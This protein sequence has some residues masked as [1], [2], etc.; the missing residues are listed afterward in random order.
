MIIASVRIIPL[1]GKRVEVLDILRHVQGLLHASAG[2]L[3]CAIYEECE[4]EPAILYL[5]QW[6]SEKEL[7]RHIQSRPYLQILAAMDLAS[8]APEICFQEVANSQGMELVEA[9]RGC[10]QNQK[11]S[12]QK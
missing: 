7:H 3:C 1:P 8:Q 4:D 2:C 12:L 6:R 5:E 10:E 9:L 11:T